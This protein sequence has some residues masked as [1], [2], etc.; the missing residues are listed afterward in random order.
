MVFFFCIY[1]MLCNYFN[2]KKKEKRLN[3]LDLILAS[4]IPAF[5]LPQPARQPPRATDTWHLQAAIPGP[6][7]LMAPG[8][9]LQGGAGQPLQPWAAEAGEPQFRPPCA[10]PSGSSTH[11][12]PSARAGQAL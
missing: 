2:L 7:S 3:K 4:G 10:R 12:S 1:L 11:P 5:C 9:S 8:P 6:G